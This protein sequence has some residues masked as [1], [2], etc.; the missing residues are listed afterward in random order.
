MFVL[1]FL[2]AQGQLF[3]VVGGLQGLLDPSKQCTETFES[4]LETTYPEDVIR[5]VPVAGGA[6]ALGGDG[7]VYAI[8]KNTNNRFGS[9]APA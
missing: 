6:V 5:V 3:G 2:L 7:S 9:D 8:G 1:A 4:V